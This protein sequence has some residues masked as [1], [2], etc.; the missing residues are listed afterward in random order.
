MKCWNRGKAGSPNA[1]KRKEPSR[2][3]NGVDKKGDTHGMEY[4]P[5]KQNPE[6]TGKQIVADWG[7]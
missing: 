7:K 2:P 6:H 4:K 1:H 3:G 5:V